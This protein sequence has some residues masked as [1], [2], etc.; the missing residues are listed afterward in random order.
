[1]LNFLSEKSKFYLLLILLILILIPLAWIML[2]TKKT[3][4]SSMYND[5]PEN[6]AQLNISVLKD[7]NKRANTFKDL[8]QL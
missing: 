3:D 5:L 2:Q 1:M 6:N 4:T 7:L 8:L